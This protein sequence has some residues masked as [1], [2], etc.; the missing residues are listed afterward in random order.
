MSKE[1]KINPELFSLRKNKTVKSKSGAKLKKELLQKLNDNETDVLK[2][3]EALTNP[4]EP[5][6]TVPVIDT[7]VTPIT[8]GCLKN[9]SM[10]TLK[11]LKRQPKMV[12]QYT[13]FGKKNGTVRVLIK[14]KE[15]Y[16]K[17]EKDKKKLDK[18][19]MTEIRN[20]LRTRR[21]YKIG[22]TA[23]DE[24]LREIYKNAYLTGNV[25]NNNN[26]TLVHNYLND[27]VKL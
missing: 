23:P 1:I 26:E 13:S 10:P 11:Q 25:E 27:D 6:E 8:Y 14:D 4:D 22:S 7:P 21:L 18:H 12:K 15:T 9:G 2:E 3:L 19:S 17:I 20:Y 16:A 5:I 24:V